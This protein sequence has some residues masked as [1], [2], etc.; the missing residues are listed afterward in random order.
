MS[1]RNVVAAVV[2]TAVTIAVTN[3]MKNN[4]A[5]RDL[6]AQAADAIE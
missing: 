1:L 6:W 2:T 5:E 3:A 4:R